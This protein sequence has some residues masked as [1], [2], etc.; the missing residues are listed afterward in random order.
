MKLSDHPLYGNPAMVKE[1]TKARMK[2]GSTVF[3][4]FQFAG[5][6]RTHSITL[7]GMLDLPLG[8]K[9]L[10]L[11][12]GVG[13][14]EKHWHNERKD[15]QFE[16]VNVSPEQLEL[17]VCPGL[18]VLADAE[19]YVSP[20]RP[21]DCVL[22]MYVLGFVGVRETLKSAYANLKPGGVM[23][24]SDAFDSTPGFD[25][26][27]SYKSPD[28]LDLLDFIAD[29]DL[30]CRQFFRLES[31]SSF[32]MSR[33]EPELLKLTL[34][35]LFILERSIH[36]KQ[37]AETSKDDGRRSTQPELCEE[38]RDTSERSEGVQPS[39]QGKEQEKVKD[40]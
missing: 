25:R 1:F 14:M 35:E 20:W 18:R 4:M 8:A 34:P 19:G 5:G 17:T 7:L 16:L 15:L 36:A 13:G 21:F 39:G 24:I 31:A 28:S 6:E 12:A 33:M 26:V 3:Q 38:G 9:V 10:S 22:L 23:V 27:F 40:A 2:E 37:D 30:T 29:S 11:G 32:V